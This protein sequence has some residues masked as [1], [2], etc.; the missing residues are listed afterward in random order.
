[1]TLKE[2][3]SDRPPDPQPDTAAAA[4]PPGGDWVHEIKQW[5]FTGSRRLASDQPCLAGGS[6]PKTPD[7]AQEG[8]VSPQPPAHPFDG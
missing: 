1:M 4:S 3:S 2:N 8:L 5:Y 7:H 6:V